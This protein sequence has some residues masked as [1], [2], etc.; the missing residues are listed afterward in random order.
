MA[1]IQR[2]DNG[3][4]RARYRDAAGKEHARHFTRK[5]DAQAWL[6]SVTASVVRGDY[7]DPGRSRVTVA[8]VAEA[9]LGNPRWTASTRARNESILARHVLPRWGTV[10]LADV[11]HE[12]VQAWV[13]DVSASGLAGGT[14][15][16]VAG[17]LAG[18]LSL[19]VKSRRLAVNPARDVELPRQSLTRRRYLT[20]GQVERLADAAGGSG[21]VVLVL[22]YCGLRIGELAALRIRHVDMLRRRF[23]VEESVTEVDGRL[24]WSAPKDHQRRSVP[25]PAFLADTL[26]VRMVGRDR[27]DL[28]FPAPQ[29]GALRVRN[30]RRGW[31]DAAA[32]EADVEGLT[33]HELRH[34][35]ASLA[36]SAGASVLS[37]QRM[38]GHDKP[39]TTLDVYSDLFDDDLD[40]VADKLT[41][42]RD[43]ALADY[44]RTAADEDAGGVVAIGG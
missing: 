24:E 16:K 9:W 14:V 19:A 23:R 39:S 30:M 25:F 1:S 41:G 43:R 21:D 17:V 26:A 3:S 7:V 37:V 5:V 33:P 8:V 11:A 34:T 13:S 2:R 12:D 38:L 42:V 22:A 18:V 31:F 4:W 40:A 27:D 28:V 36:V 35:A 15:R 44:L 10:R 6:D 20:A 32:V 29:G